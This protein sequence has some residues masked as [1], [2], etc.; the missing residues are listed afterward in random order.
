MWR[1]SESSRTTIAFLGAA[2]FSGKYVIHPDHIE[3]VH[4]VFSPSEA[5]IVHARTVLAAWDDAQANG[6]GA[7]WAG[8]VDLGARYWPPMQNELGLPAGNVSYGAMIVGHPK[9]KYHR[10]P[11]RR[12]ARIS[13]K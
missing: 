12:E 5:E 10:I 4:G 6:L 7:C 13:W 8:Y 11:L 3:P 2:G 1:L 9:Y